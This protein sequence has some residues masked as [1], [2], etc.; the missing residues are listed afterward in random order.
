M[1]VKEKIEVK[2]YMSQ[3]TQLT[4]FYRY[5]GYYYYYEVSR[6]G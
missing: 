1:G 4:D 2:L 3:P 5:F 6:G